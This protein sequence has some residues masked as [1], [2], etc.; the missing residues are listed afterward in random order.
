MEEQTKNKEETRKQMPIRI[1]N[2]HMMFDT[3]YPEQ[4]VATIKN[5][6]RNKI[7]N[8]RNYLREL[9]RELMSLMEV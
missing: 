8:A 4:A 3:K 9:D 1:G 7:Q 5:I 2:I 6:I